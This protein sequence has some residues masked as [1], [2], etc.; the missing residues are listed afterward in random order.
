MP[1]LGCGRGQ[2]LSGKKTKKREE[3]LFAPFL[4]LQNMWEISKS[5]PLHEDCVK[6]SAIVLHHGTS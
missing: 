6:N 2:S 1:D 4:L 5:L 3:K